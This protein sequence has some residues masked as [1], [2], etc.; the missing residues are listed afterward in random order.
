M[1]EYLLAA[2]AAIVAIRLVRGPTFA[3]RM[4]SADAISSIVVLYIVY[5]SVMNNPAF[6]DIAVVAAMLSFLG[7][8]AIAKYVVK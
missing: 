7:T 1:I 4:I 3:D 5:Y 2:A 6:M 8:I